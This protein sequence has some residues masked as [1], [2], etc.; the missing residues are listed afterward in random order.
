M[1][2]A[3]GGLPQQE[4]ARM[5]EWVAGED[6]SHYTEF[7]KL[8]GYSF[9]DDFVFAEDDELQDIVRDAAMK[10]P[11][12]RR[13]LRAVAKLRHA[14]GDQGPHFTG[15]L[16]SPSLTVSPTRIDEPPALEDAPA[17]TGSEQL[18]KQRNNVSAAPSKRVEPEAQAGSFAPLSPQ[19]QATAIKTAA[20]KAAA[21][22]S[23]KREEE[24]ELARR[25]AEE[26]IAAVEAEAFRAAQVATGTTPTV[27]TPDPSDSRE[28][29][30]AGKNRAKL[31]AKRKKKAAAAAGG[32]VKGADDASERQARYAKAGAVASMMQSLVRTVHSVHVV[33]P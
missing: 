30:P 21:K 4:K 15:I 10:R 19:A 20:V 27:A 1:L 9:V 12:G 13:F 16:A 6:L 32:A 33:P 26:A 3:D 18:N 28:I 22:I 31:K 7:F 17:L 5:E 23:A 24:V 14:V 8:Q 25:H 2:F 29:T 11:E